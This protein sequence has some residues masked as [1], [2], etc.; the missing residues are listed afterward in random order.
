MNFGSWITVA[1]VLFATLI[2]SLVVVCVRQDVSLVSA[3]YYQQEIKYQSRID[4]MSNAKAALIK[5]EVIRVTGDSHLEVWF[6]E[7]SSV[8]TGEVIM[9]RPSDASLDKTFALKLD[10]NGRFRM[11]TSPLKRGLWKMKI[12]W[13]QGGQSYFEEKT[14]VI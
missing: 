7:Q 1:F 6:G 5:L 12:S 9:F 14:I 8:V 4:D 10:K 13:Q 2:I 3:D 11:D